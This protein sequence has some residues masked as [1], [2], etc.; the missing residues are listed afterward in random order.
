[1]GYRSQVAFK[2][3]TEGFVLMKTWNDEII[4]RENR[5][6][7]G[8]DIQKTPTG[9]YKISHDEIKWY[10]SFP[11]IRYFIEFMDKLEKLDIPF[12]FIRIGEDMDDIEVRNNYTDD[13]PDEIETFAPETSIYDEDEG[14]YED[15]KL[16]EGE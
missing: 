7:V 15:V 13:M 11:D 3:T 1:M 12:C 2:T 4:P 16:D 6:L 14:C 8:M 9:F 10:E 5:P